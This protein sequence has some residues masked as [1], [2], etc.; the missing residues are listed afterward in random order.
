M[1]QRVSSL[2]CVAPEA[3]I[4]RASRLEKSNSIVTEPRA[5]ATGLLFR[6]DFFN[7]QRAGR[8][9]SRFCNHSPLVFVENSTP[10]IG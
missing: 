9:R 6:A 4:K 5:V 8:Y 3:V 10:R 7:N 1:R 2:K